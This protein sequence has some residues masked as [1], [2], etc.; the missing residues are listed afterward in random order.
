MSLDPGSVWLDGRGAQSMAHSGRG[1]PRHVS[2]LIPALVEA[3][4]EAIG[5][6][7]LDPQPAG[8][9]RAGAL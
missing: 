2:E 4:P 3:A 8:P 6:I 1:I 5:A 9:A 7:G